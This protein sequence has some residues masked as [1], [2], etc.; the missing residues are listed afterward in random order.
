MR[1]AWAISLC[2]ACLYQAVFILDGRKTTIMRKILGWVRLQA[3]CRTLCISHSSSAGS[4]PLKT[5]W[6]WGYPKD[7][8]GLLRSVSSLKR[9]GV[10]L[11]STSSQ[12]LCCWIE[13]KAL[14]LMPTR[15]IAMLFHL[16][17]LMSIVQDPPCGARRAP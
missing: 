7:H 16:I 1:G 13:G 10:A 14:L 17:L 15:D 2:D 9:R 5:L 8:Q 11:T 12:A 4:S 3:N 6:L